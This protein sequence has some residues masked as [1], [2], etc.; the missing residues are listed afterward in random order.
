MKNENRKS[1]Y[2]D[3]RKKAYPN[4]EKKILSFD[5]LEGVI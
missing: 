5:D 3:L 1:F 2:K 4:E